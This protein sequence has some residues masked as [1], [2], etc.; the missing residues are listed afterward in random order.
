MI[1]INLKNTLAGAS[2]SL[3]GEGKQCLQAKTTPAGPPQS[4]GELCLELLQH[5]M[6]YENPSYW[7]RLTDG[8]RILCFNFPWVRDREC[9]YWLRRAMWH[10]HTD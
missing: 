3:S 6:N 10:K 2:P 9:A 4:L 5:K 1:H 8:R 7:D